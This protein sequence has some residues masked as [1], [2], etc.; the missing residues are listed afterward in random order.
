MSY[1][2]KILF[3]ASNLMQSHP[4][5]A[6]TLE[7]IALGVRRVERA[8]DEMVAEAMEEEQMRYVCASIPP[9]SA[10]IVHLD[11]F[12]TVPISGSAP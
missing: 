3:V 7:N 5:Y 9:P 12:R 11:R 8:L 10:Q 6:V 4:D 1:A 2:D